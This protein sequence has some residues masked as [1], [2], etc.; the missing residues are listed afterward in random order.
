MG[1]T[2]NESLFFNPGEKFLILVENRGQLCSIVF[3]TFQDLLPS[4]WENN[5]INRLGVDGAV[6]Q[7]S[8]SM[9]D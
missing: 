5:V 4:G 7:A 6:L 1:P 8:L 9:I 3:S 2:F